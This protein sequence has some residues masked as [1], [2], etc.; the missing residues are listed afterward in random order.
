MLTS[1]FPH[2]CRWPGS[3]SWCSV[4]ELIHGCGPLWFI[5]R[6]CCSAVLPRCCQFP[7]FSCDRCYG[8]RLGSDVAY[9]GTH[10]HK[11]EFIV[12]NTLVSS[13]GVCRSEFFILPVG[14]ALGLPCVRG[15]MRIQVCIE[16]KCRSCRE[17]ACAFPGLLMSLLA[18][19]SLGVTFRKERTGAVCDQR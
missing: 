19:V 11:Q 8:H 10:R 7:V 1:L 17:P 2:G 4:R 12:T 3:L 16:E 6:F 9:G 13:P 18:H 5:A 15:C 14:G